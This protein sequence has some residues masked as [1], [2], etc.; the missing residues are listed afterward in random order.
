M[1]PFALVIIVGLASC[2]GLAI[3]PSG[4][5]DSG[6]NLDGS[7]ESGPAAADSAPIDAGPCVFDE[8]NWQ[9]GNLVLE[10]CPGPLGPKPGG[11][12][13][14]IAPTYACLY[15]A[16]NGT[17]RTGEEFVCTREP[18]SPPPSPGATWTGHMLKTATF[19]CSMP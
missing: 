7:S 16:E 11:L 10:T 17:G 8:G 18:G 3:G 1:R 5:D 19:P 6:S 9:C 4:G 12:C 15:C 14:S 2:G 13:S